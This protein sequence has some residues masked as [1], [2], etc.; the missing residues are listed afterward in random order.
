M[1][2]RDGECLCGVTPHLG[3]DSERLLNVGGLKGNR[4]GLHRE[5][6][7]MAP[8]FKMT[9]SWKMSIEQRLNPQDED[10]KSI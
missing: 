1:Q 10:G 2:Q 3:T 4:A 7:R 6:K 8:I 9:R 5:P